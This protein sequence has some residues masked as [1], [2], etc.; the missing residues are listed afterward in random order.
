M[1]DC[2]DQQQIQ[3]YLRG[4][5]GN[6]AAAAVEAHYFECDRCFEEIELGLEVRAAVAEQRGKARVPGPLGLEPVGAPRWRPLLALAAVLLVAV[7]LVWL[8]PQRLQSP[9]HEVV[10][11][12]D[13]GTV[14]TI[15]VALDRGDVRVEWSDVPGASSYLARALDVDGSVVV[16]VEVAQGPAVLEAL[17]DQPAAAM[18]LTVE[19]EA[20]DGLRQT[21]ARSQQERIEGTTNGR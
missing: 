13:G 20:L 8:V 12:T 9:D 19:V 16:E 15:D 18:G 21:V 4:A 3:R 5:L 17:L 10:R 1:N 14:W 11:G 7:G 2:P 6:D